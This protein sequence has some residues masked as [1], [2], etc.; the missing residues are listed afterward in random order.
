MNS[1][2]VLEILEDTAHPKRTE[3]V[4]QLVTFLSDGINGMCFTG[5]VAPEE[6]RA[7]NPEKDTKRDQVLKAFAAGDESATAAVVQYINE[8]RACFSVGFGGFVEDGAR[9]TFRDRA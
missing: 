7:G 8:D 1:Q 4:S 3:V 6:T 2:E 5:Q 9:Y